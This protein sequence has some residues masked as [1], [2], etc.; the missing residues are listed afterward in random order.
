MGKF[1]IWHFTSLWLDFFEL[2]TII[3]LLARLLGNLHP[4]LQIK[5]NFECELTCAKNNFVLELVEIN[6]LRLSWIK[7]VDLLGTHG[8]CIRLLLRT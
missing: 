2:W 4:R 6:R 5:V 1:Q 8:S 7:S 3:L